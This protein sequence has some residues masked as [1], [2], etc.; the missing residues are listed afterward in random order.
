MSGSATHWDV[1]KCIAEPPIPQLSYHMLVAEWV[2][3]QHTPNVLRN[4]PF[5]NFLTDPYASCG[6]GDSATHWEVFK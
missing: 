6:M 2:V 1:F 3:P 4:H 5:R